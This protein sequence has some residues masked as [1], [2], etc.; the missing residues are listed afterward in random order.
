MIPFQTLAACLLS[1]AAAAPAATQGFRVQWD[2]GLRLESGGG[3]VAIMVGG[4]IQADF[5]GFAVGNDV[6]EAFGP[7]DNN[8]ELRR[9]RMFVSA[10]IH[11]DLYFRFQAD[12]AYSAG[13][14]D[15]Y[16]EYRGLP[17]R[18][19]AGHFKEP[20]GL[21][22]STSSKYSTF[23]ERGLTN[24]A[25]SPRNTGFTA[26]LNWYPTAT[27]RWMVNAI[28]ARRSGYDAFWSFATRLQEAF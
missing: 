21:E 15:L 19:R 12:G 2:E 1:A 23:M 9:A 27:T 8:A 28:R 17:V 18:L 3:A 14:K 7:F 6:D 25:I 20:M 16:F 26:G 13:L 24:A 10:T 11:D 5:G 22:G 4:R